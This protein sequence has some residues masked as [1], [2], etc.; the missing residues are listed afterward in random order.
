MS[1]SEATHSV[2]V[3]LE[4]KDSRR[5]PGPNL[6]W[7]DRVGAI[8]DVAIAGIAPERVVSAWRGHARR[9]L[10]ALGWTQEALAHRLF[11]GGA[12]LVSSAP[13]DGLYTA[14]EVNEFAWQAAVCELLGQATPG[15]AAVLERLRALRA[16]EANPAAMALWAEAR[17]RGLAC[18]VDERQVN[19]GTGCGSRTWPYRE[20][21]A[22]EQVDWRA[23]HD[24]PCA[25]VTGTNGKSTSVRLLGAVAKAAGKIPGL[26][27]T[28]WV[29]VGDQI[30]DHG[31]W[32]GPAGA[33]MVLRDPRVEIAIL[34][35]AR[36]GM[37][38]RGLV[39]EKVDAALITNVAED[40]L[41]EWG[42]TCLDDLVEAKFVIRRAA[43]TLVLNADDS[44]V[45]ARGRHIERPVAWFSRH[46]Q[47]EWLVQHVRAGGAA[48]VAADGLITWLQG[49][50]RTPIV[51]VAEIP[52][53][54][55]GAARHNVENCL[56]VAAVAMLLGL[57]PAAVAAGLKSFESTPEEN[58][59]RLN[60]FQLHGVTAVVD[61]A[62][63]PHGMDAILDMA[64]A[65]P[66]RRRA[67]LLGQAGDRDDESIREF[68]RA[69]WR[70][71]PDLVIIK[72]M[73]RYLRGRAPGEVPRII[74]AELRRVGAP[75][76]AIAHAPSEMAAVHQALT[77]ARPGDLLLLLSHAEREA[78][79]AL[80][81]QLRDAGWAPGQP[82]PAAD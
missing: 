38:R 26:S 23:L 78:V 65:M 15:D 2:P 9:L 28:D 12:N 75:A 7:E 42:A 39:M 69:T 37:L 5:L 36:G 80:M 61:F 72:E 67:V 47:Q 6:Y 81:R 68:T 1:A 66:A 44:A 64:R 11:P 8:L 34:E 73:Q 55:G 33:R 76:E 17:R 31:D 30:L 29:R 53:T 45:R 57:P 24:V 13:W 82:L 22:P 49:A 3:V 71:Q 10:D 63:N 19:L 27:S 77:W 25:M 4:Q 52:I 62:H 74:E 18:V 59:G 41:G 14:T 56:G 16:R 43:R 48:C 50:Q 20:V 79:I 60:V 40:H 32:S 35:T 51:A 46:P 70:A 21:P 58:P 54:V